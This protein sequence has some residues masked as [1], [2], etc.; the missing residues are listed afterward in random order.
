MLSR[1]PGFIDRFILGD[2]SD[3]AILIGVLVFLLI[4]L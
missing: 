3:L 4:L 1:I 2:S